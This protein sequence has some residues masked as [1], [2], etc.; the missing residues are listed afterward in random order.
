MKKVVS[1]TEDVVASPF[2][3]DNMRAAVHKVARALIL[4][5]KIY[6]Q[7]DS[8][9]DGYT[10]AAVLINYLHSVLPGTV[11]NNIS[12][13]LHDEKTHGIDIDE[14]SSNNY[15]LVIVPDAS[16][17]ENEIH[18]SLAAH[19][20]DV[21]VLDHH[22]ATYDEDDPAIIV[23]NQMSE[24]YNNSALSGVG[25]VYQFCKAFDAL[26]GFDNA[27]NFLDLVAVGNI[28]DMMDLR[29]PE[30]R[31]FIN[32]GLNN[33]QNLFLKT[34]I[35]KQS[36]VMKNELNPFTIA[37]Y[38]VPLINAVTRVGTEEEK[39]SLFLGLID[40]YATTIC[41]STRRGRVPGETET[42]AARA[43][44]IV[45]TVKNRQEK[46]KKQSIESLQPTVNK[47]IEEQ[48]PILIIK[49]PI[50][51]GGLTG[52]LAN[53]YMALYRKPCFLLHKNEEGNW[54]GSARGFI[55]EEV[56]DWR[57]YMEKTGDVVFAEGHPFAFGIEFTDAGLAN[58][59]KKIKLGQILTKPTEKMYEV[60]FEW[61]NTDDFDKYILAI[62]R[63]GYLW[64][65]GLHEP[66]VVL[67]NMKIYKSN[68]S[69]LKNDTIK[70]NLKNHTTTLIKFKDP[71]VCKTFSE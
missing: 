6:I 2:A 18:K 53:Y 12:W 69:L 11:E 35:E 71:E 10:S 9:C 61:N 51:L 31:Y 16:S 21:V 25:I 45:S 23:N 47:I 19:G 67:K 5:H 68:I 8:D 26:M 55:T 65:Q 22:Q 44:R 29:S 15:D 59:T 50:E 58:F 57:G 42:I 33:I 63:L 28:G 13:G 41:A 70:F 38:I 66:Y 30:T 40:Y 32:Q 64:G 14:V 34:L 49:S 20:I 36:F 60:D 56:K 48:Q 46:E 17:N 62:A 43:A 3:L 39:K 4:N 54:S 52:L 7:V 1:P 24:F 27:D 37:F